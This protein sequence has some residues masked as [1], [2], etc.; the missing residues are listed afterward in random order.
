MK[1][2]MVVLAVVSMSCGYQPTWELYVEQHHM[3]HLPEYGQAIYTIAGRNTNVA[4]GYVFDA[5]LSD[6]S[7]RVGPTNLEISDL[8]VI[9]VDS[10]AK[11]DN[12]QKLVWANGSGVI[13]QATRLQLYGAVGE[14]AP[15]SQTT[16]M[17]GTPLW[18]LIF[19]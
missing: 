15:D 18:T 3:S 10:Q 2:T 7:V 12:G 13:L 4:E 5:K 6:V 17:V 8:Y 19:S 1:R 11:F 14:V 16:P 9:R